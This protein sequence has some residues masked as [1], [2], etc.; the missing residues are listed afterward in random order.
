[1]L[2]T[3]DSWAQSGLIRIDREI[4]IFWIFFMH[5]HIISERDFQTIHLKI[6]TPKK[7]FLGVMI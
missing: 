6:I 3:R 7:A 5:A 2:L 4:R 1:M